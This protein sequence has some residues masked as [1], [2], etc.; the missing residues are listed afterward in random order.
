MSATLSSNQSCCRLPVLPR[1]DCEESRWTEERA[2]RSRVRFEVQF[3]VVVVDM[4][5]KDWAMTLRCS[6][7]VFWLWAACTLSLC[8]GF[9]LAA[10]GRKV[11]CNVERIRQ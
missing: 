6:S 11:S 5:D 8:I 2:C 10:G 1:V 7:Q 9:C 3:D 4:R